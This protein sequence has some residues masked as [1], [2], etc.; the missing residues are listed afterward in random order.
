MG[1]RVHL[2]APFLLKALSEQ[3]SHVCISELLYV[4]AGHASAMC[5]G[6]N[7]IPNLNEGI[8]GERT[9]KTLLDTDN[10]ICVNSPQPVI[11]R[12][13][14]LPALQGILLTGVVVFILLLKTSNCYHYSNVQ[15][16]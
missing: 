8:N 7:V 11:S 5:S 16:V 1:H 4:P 12:L 2:A 3:L 6:I 9:I 14:T 15:N 13:A 10:F